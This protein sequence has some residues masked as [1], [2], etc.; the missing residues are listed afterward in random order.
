MKHTLP[1]AIVGL[2]MLAGCYHLVEKPHLANSKL[3]ELFDID[4]SGEFTPN[5]V[6]HSKGLAE[7]AAHYGNSS[8][9]GVISIRAQGIELHKEGFK[10]FEKMPNLESITLGGRN[11]TLTDND[12]K[13]LAKIRL[14]NIKTIGLSKAPNITTDGISALLRSFPTLQEVGIIGCSKISE[15][16]CRAI[17]S[18]LPSCKIVGWWNFEH[19]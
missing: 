14:P 4:T 2:T 5:G 17:E 1:A 16:D 18:I 19:G 9:H 6:V 8:L 12:L 7:I 15:K 3:R 13:K 11:S 10:D